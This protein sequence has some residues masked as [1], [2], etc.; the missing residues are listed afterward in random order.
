[1][2]AAYHGIIFVLLAA[3]A[4]AGVVATAHAHFTPNGK[5]RI[6]ILDRMADSLDLYLRIPAP[7]IY[8]REL[9]ERAYPGARVEAPFLFAE[10]AGGAWI[11]SLDLDA[12][13]AETAAFGEWVAGG[14]RIT[15]NGRE[16]PADM[17]AFGV[18]PER[19]APPFA[20]PQDARAAMNMA[21]DDHPNPFVG[22]AVVDIALRI[23]N[24]DGYGDVVVASILPELQLP[25]DIFIDNH[26]LDFNGPEIRVLTVAGQLQEG[27]LLDLSLTWSIMTFV[28]EGIWHILEGFDHVLFVLCLT[29]AASSFGV[30][31][32]NVTGFTLGH[33]L[34][35]IAGFLGLTPAFGWF[36]PAV[37]TAI[38][39]SIVYAGLIALFG[40]PWGRGF[41]IATA[42]GLLHGFGFS[43]VLANIL[44]REAPNLMVSLLSF[45]V[46]VEIGQLL[47]VSV[48]WFLLLAVQRANRRFAIGMR[49][50]VA[51]GSIGIACVWAVERVGILTGSI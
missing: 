39:A 20:T 21:A 13:A 33:S 2:R 45:N 31:V 24:V 6:I 30:L 26:I 27:V 37:E 1:M 38:A 40:K 44:G 32:W 9:S 36:V 16:K 28:A 17:T 48:A 50:A 5:N 3:M 4:L 14:Y 49:A 23:E 22:E 25:P 35:L 10:N 46:G 29:L 11:H 51:T 47:I 18:Y 8:S 41:W 42:I 43:F 7:L 12:I 34:T 19:T 15:V